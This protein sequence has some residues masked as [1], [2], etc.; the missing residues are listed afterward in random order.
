[1]VNKEKCLELIN[2]IE[3]EYYDSLPYFYKDLYELLLD[4]IHT[5]ENSKE[6]DDED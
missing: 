3:Q 5:F 4:F 1:M 2:I 6:E